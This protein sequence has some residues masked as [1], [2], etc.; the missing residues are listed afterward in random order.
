MIVVLIGKVLLSVLTLN[1][2]LP[3]DG[4]NA[5][6]VAGQHDQGHMALEAINALEREEH[7]DISGKAIALH[8][9][10]RW[11]VTDLDDM[12][13]EIECPRTNGSHCP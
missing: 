3:Q 13:T 6:D 9:H 1:D 5:M 11:G 12:F 7:E 4:T 8:Q 2:W 10:P